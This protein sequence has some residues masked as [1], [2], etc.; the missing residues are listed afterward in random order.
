MTISQV[1]K[2]I[3]PFIH[4]SQKIQSLGCYIVLQDFFDLIKLIFLLNA[5]H[6]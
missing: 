2:L 4:N 5:T 1:S 3:M 6:N